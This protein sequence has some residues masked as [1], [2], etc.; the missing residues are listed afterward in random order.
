MVNIQKSNKSSQKLA[1]LASTFVSNVKQ[2]IFDWKQ[3]CY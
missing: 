1:K 2:N 3:Y